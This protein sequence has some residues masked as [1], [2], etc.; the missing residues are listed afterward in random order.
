MRTV[1]A[2]N[3]FFVRH[4]GKTFR[5][6]NITELP[7]IIKYDDPWGI[8]LYFQY[9]NNF[10]ERNHYSNIGGYQC[11]GKILKKKHNYY[12]EISK[13]NVLFP[14]VVTFR[15]QEYFVGVTYDRF[16][17]LDQITLWNDKTDIVIRENINS[18]D[19]LYRRVISCEESY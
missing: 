13:I 6:F 17:K 8:W 14:Y 4:P 12:V 19:I 15:I 10:T 11:C 5:S 7:E 18:P 2:T 1:R 16:N 3:D 9:Y